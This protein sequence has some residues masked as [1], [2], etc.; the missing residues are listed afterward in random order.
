MNPSF[1]TTNAQ[2]HSQTHGRPR[3]WLEPA[4]GL[5]RTP[6]IVLLALL[7]SV[8]VAQ[9]AGYSL[10]NA[11]TALQATPDWQSANL[12]YQTAQRS[13]ET[14]QA[15]T[16]INL[17]AGG[18]YNGL[19]PSSGT[20]TNSASVSV[21]AS[22]NVLPWSAAY[23]TI[24]SAQR[25]F[26]RASLTLRDTRNSLALTTVS[27]YFSARNSSLNLQAAQANE[28]LL[29]GRLRV[30]NLQYQ[31]GQ[32]A[33]ADLLT[34]QQNL[35]TA[36]STTLSAQNALAIALAQL[37]VPATT[38]FTTAPTQLDLPQGTLEALVKAALERRADVLQAASR[39]QDADDA[40]GNAQRNRV[41]PN[42]SLSLGVGQLS[43]TGSLGSPSLTGSVN[44]QSGTTSL[45]GS[46]PLT[47]NT[48]SGTGTGLSVSISASFPVLG[49]SLDA[50]INA[51]QTALD[52]AKANLETVRRAAAIDVA[53]RISTAQVSVAQIKAASSAVDSAQKTFET[54]TARNKAG[55]NTAIDL[56]AARVNLL[57]AQAN[58][59]TTLASQQSAVY[60]LQNAIGTLNL[61]QVP[62]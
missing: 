18:S 11:F 17:S 31:N 47:T 35:A 29:T 26:E 55:L 10:Q 23:D 34:A 60:Q 5:R 39:V 54:A 1:K 45:T 40:L 12:T 48:G 36:Q 27:S 22:A 21:T 41:L 53:Q 15:A 2:R 32:I 49:P 37:G 59:E 43:A 58:L 19:F 20:S 30:A 50:S 4:R 61:V 7:G 52:A 28:A 3:R 62:G 8:A 42:A 38:K 14:A 13:L 56:E 57:Q 46:V 25:A 44:L 33:F 24:R 9:D 6:Q 16:G 51:A